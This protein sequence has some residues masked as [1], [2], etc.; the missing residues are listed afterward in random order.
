[1]A[2]ISGTA[3]HFEAPDLSQVFR[4]RVFQLQFGDTWRSRNEIGFSGFLLLMV[5][6]SET[7]TWHGAKTL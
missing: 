6:K 7:T 4:N 5:K 2:P 1:M 3:I